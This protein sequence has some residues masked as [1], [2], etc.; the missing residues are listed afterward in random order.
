M[1]PMMFPHVGW[2]YKMTDMS[3]TAPSRWSMWESKKKHPLTHRKCHCWL[4]VWNWILLVH[5]LGIIIPTDFHI[6]Q[7]GSNHT[8]IGFPTL[9]S[10]KLSSGV[11][12]DWH[13]AFLIKDIYPQP[14]PGRPCAAFWMALFGC[15]CPG[16][17]PVKS[18]KRRWTSSFSKLTTCG[19]VWKWG[20]QAYT[21]WLFNIAMENHHF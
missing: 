6:F 7:T 18:E 5:R 19:C 1:F 16:N 20:L 4:V 11:L 12:R 10:S 3:R 13:L 15:L 17:F 8:S 9:L 14:D 21:L 2:W